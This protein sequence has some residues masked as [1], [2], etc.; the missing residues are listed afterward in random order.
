MVAAE[1]IW[2]IV[3]MLMDG[4]LA[5][6][7]YLVYLH[8]LPGLVAGA[9]WV[10]WALGGYMGSRCA[11]PVGEARI[12]TQSQLTGEDTIMGILYGR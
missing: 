8:Y 11:R 10:K 3:D 7:N 6:R 9:A 2:A 5:S 4:L 1:P 12:G